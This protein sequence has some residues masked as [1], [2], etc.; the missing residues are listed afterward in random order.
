MSRDAPNWDRDQCMYTQHYPSRNLGVSVVNRM[1]AERNNPKFKPPA[2]QVPVGFPCTSY[3]L[4]YGADRTVEERLN[5]K[6]PSQNPGSASRVSPGLGMLETVSFS[7]SQHKAV[8]KDIASA[9]MSRSP[10]APVDSLHL[11]SEPHPDSLMRSSYAGAFNTCRATTA[12]G[13]T[14]TMYKSLSSV[15]L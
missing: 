13:R 15:D 2:P 1:L 11:I 10:G 3:D 14:R 5:A 4:E 9:F 7:H 12:G 8:D 6:L